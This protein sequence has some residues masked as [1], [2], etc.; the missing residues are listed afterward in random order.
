MSEMQYWQ[1]SGLE[2]MYH[3]T[4]G[5]DACMTN[6]V[7]THLVEEL[8]ELNA[9]E[10]VLKTQIDDVKK[11]I[12]NYMGDKVVLKDAYGNDL[13]TYKFDKPQERFDAKSFREKHPNIYQMF[14]TLGKPVRR[15]LVK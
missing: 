14:V 8:R 11:R 15:M 5:D 10:R 4:M 1:Q 3:E 12:A 9:A 2:Q 6:D 7:I 13:V